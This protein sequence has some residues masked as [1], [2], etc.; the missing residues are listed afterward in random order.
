MSTWEITSPQRLELDG[1]VGELEVWLASGKLHVVGT[2]G[3]ARIEVTR[4]G[5]KGVDVALENGRLSV[6]HTIPS[7]WWRRGPFW[8]F[9]GGR[10]RY[11]AHVTIAVPPTAHGRLTLVSGS[12][13]ASGLREGANASVTSGSITLMGLGGA[14][15]AK[16]VSG[17]IQAMGVSGDLS[18]ST[19]SGEISLAESSAERVRA[20]TIS[21][22]VTCDLDNPFAREVRLDTTSG[23]ITVRVP[24]DADLEVSL[25]ATSGRV[26]SAFP[27]VR[28]VGLP[29]MHSA[30]G[31]IG[32]GS[33]SLRAYAVSGA[34]SLLSR[35]SSDDDLSA[36]ADGPSDPPEDSR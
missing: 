8:W 2:P 27:Q 4:V 30:S 25:N 21:G 35:P 34:V 13:V 5:S 19:I 36:P 18:M 24:E 28:T 29:G 17:S 14:V 16:T 6:R 33:G 20:H 31:R 11:L 9:L 23:E 10:Q 22:A 12:L 7:A 1:D 26:I 32:T 3:P 15:S